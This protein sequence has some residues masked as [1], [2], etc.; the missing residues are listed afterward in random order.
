MTPA[1]VSWR[2]AGLRAV[3]AQES[4]LQQGMDAPCLRP[5]LAAD[6]AASLCEMPL[7]TTLTTGFYIPDRRG[8]PPHLVCAV[9]TLLPPAKTE[10]NKRL[11]RIQSCEIQCYD[12]QACFNARRKQ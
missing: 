5:R 3:P 4:I 11:I 9:P 6:E 8:V 2:P 1:P 10:A 7:R 12:L